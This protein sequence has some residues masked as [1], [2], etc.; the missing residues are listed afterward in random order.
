MEQLLITDQIL[1]RYQISERTLYDWKTRLGFPYIAIG[2]D[3]RYSLSDILGWEEVYKMNRRTKKET[4]GPK[5]AP[6][7]NLTRYLALSS[8][9]KGTTV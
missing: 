9:K 5:K 6:G 1:F 4:S 2:R 3:H 7:L 8:N